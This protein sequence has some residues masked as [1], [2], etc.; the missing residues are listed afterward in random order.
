MCVI[1]CCR[2]QYEAYLSL[3]NVS[4][5]GLPEQVARQLFARFD[6]NQNDTLQLAEFSEMMAHVLG[7]ELK[8]EE[9]HGLYN[10]IEN[11]HDELTLPDF[12]EFFRRSDETVRRP[13]ALFMHPRL[14][15]LDLLQQARLRLALA[16]HHRLHGVGGADAQRHGHAVAAAGGHHQQLCGNVFEEKGEGSTMKSSRLTLSQVL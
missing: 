10:I 8:D 9:V 6:E 4:A 13:L 5:R 1:V 11:S 7:Q 16:L 2:T 15:Q 14:V 3:R 12:L